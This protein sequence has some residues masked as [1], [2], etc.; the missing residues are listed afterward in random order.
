MI[1]AEFFGILFLFFG[2]GMLCGAMLHA[3]LDDRSREEP[4]YF[5][6]FIERVRYRDEFKKRPLHELAAGGQELTDYIKK[7]EKIFNAENRD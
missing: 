4:D 5:P 1:A 6:S 7:M 2:F 3:G